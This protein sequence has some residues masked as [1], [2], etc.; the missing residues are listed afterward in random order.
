MNLTLVT[1]YSMFVVCLHPAMQHYFIRLFY[2]ITFNSDCNPRISCKTFLWGAVDLMLL[3]PFKRLSHTYALIH[4]KSHAAFINTPSH[5]PWSPTSDMF[6]SSV[7]DCTQE[8]TAIYFLSP[9]VEEWC[10][11]FRYSLRTEGRLWKRSQLRFS[12]ERESPLLFLCV[13]VVCSWSPQD[14]VWFQ[15]LPLLRH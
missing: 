14:I 2:L 4:I 15:T 12:V 9:T 5:T 8:I 7:H 3:Q 13:W 11:G 10:H 1:L 6:Q